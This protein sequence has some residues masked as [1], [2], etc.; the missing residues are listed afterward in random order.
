MLRDEG[1]DDVMDFLIG[2][3]TR[4]GGPGIALLRL[5][6]DELTMIWEDDRFTDP[7]WLSPGPDGRVYAVSSDMPG[8]EKGCVNA[9]EVTASGLRL[10]GR[11]P[12]GGNASCHIGIS[13]DGRFLLAANYLSGSLAVF[14]LRDGRIAPRIQLLRH[15]GRSVHPARQTA[16]H[17]H[18]ATYVPHLPGMVC[19]VD[20]GTDAL[21]IYEQDARTGLL[22]ER[23]QVCLP[24]GEGPRH[25]AY[26]P[27][28]AC[29]L[30]TELGNKIYSVCLSPDGGCLSDGVSTLGDPQC[31]STAAAIKLSADAKRVYVSNRGEDSIAE[32]SP[33][34]LQKTAVWK[35]V[36]KTPRDFTLL[37]DNK[38]LVACQG[39]GVKLLINGK[40]AASLPLHGSVCVLPL[41]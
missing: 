4:L 38:A 1:D 27:D 5:E 24:P 18:Q 41:P 12:T 30:A 37:P 7:N 22:S 11:Q 2:T 40:I 13:P 20:L 14:P 15:E 6:N 25:V 8:P 33:Y 10:L 31:D 23:Y 36:G 39:E 29:F 19:A 26:G 3:L 28:G 32:F 16:P 9:L 35:H 21:V 34:P 17:V